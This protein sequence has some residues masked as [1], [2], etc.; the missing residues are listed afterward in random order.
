MADQC[1]NEQLKMTLLSM[2]GGQKV[3]AVLLGILQGPQCSSFTLHSK[4][5]MWLVYNALSTLDDSGHVALELELELMK[6]IARP[7]S[8]GE[9]REVTTIDK[10][11]DEMRK[12]ILDR[13]SPYQLLSITMSTD[14]GSFALDLRIILALI[15][16]MELRLCNSAYTS[17]QNQLIETYL[18]IIKRTNILLHNL[19]QEGLEIKLVLESLCS[20]LSSEA[21]AVVSPDLQ[22]L[23]C[24][25]FIIL[26]KYHSHMKATLPDLWIYSVPYQCYLHSPTGG[27]ERLENDVI[28]HAL[29]HLISSSLNLPLASSMDN[30]ESRETPLNLQQY[31]YFSTDSLFKVILLLIKEHNENILYEWAQHPAMQYVWPVCL[32]RLV[33]W[34]STVPQWASGESEQ[35]HQW[36]L[37]KRVLAVVVI[38]ELQNMLGHSDNNESLPQY[39][40]DAYKYVEQLPWLH[41]VSR[42]FW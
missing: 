11:T 8:K 33:Q 25:I 37:L 14:T 12:Y 39:D 29:E 20:L 19:T 2:T 21:F 1:C 22:T 15:F 4:V 10:P 5:W 24:K 6:I 26:D 34:T 3:F 35:F 32:S 28:P 13:L 7:L 38:G 30:S 16:R 17:N 23:V 18:T 9:S 42:S 36:D 40:Y 31:P 27:G 41:E